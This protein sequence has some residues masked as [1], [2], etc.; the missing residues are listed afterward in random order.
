MLDDALDWELI[1][2]AR[3]ALERGER[4][5]LEREVRN[6]NRAVG[7]LLSSEIARRR[8]GAGLPRRAPRSRSTSGLGRAELR[9]L[10]GARA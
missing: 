5:R 9:R 1:E 3:P 4:V 7:G 8:G 6:V 10:A 2:A